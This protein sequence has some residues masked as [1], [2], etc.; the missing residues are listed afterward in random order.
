MKMMRQGSRAM[1][2]LPELIECEEK[3]EEEYDLFS[4][5]HKKIYIIKDLN[6][7]GRKG[8]RHRSLDGGRNKINTNN[9]YNYDVS[10]T[11]EEDWISDDSLNREKGKSQSKFSR[12]FNKIY[13]DH[14]ERPI[15]MKQIKDRNKQ[16]NKTLVDTPIN[17][18]SNDSSDESKVENASDNSSS[19]FSFKKK[20]IQA[21][22]DK[23]DQPSTK[24]V[25][26]SHKYYE[27]IVDP[28]EEDEDEND[29]GET[30]SLIRSETYE[31]FKT[32]NTRWKVFGKM[33]GNKER[34]PMR[35][36]SF[37][38]ETTSFENEPILEEND[39]E[40]D[41]PDPYYH[42]F[43]VGKQIDDSKSVNKDAAKLL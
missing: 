23:A 2:I 39:E 43:K 1:D 36:K 20:T 4:S 38:F 41:Q 7:F 34:V 29:N 3:L 10:E 21:F 35:K 22:Y 5:R 11:E 26:T 37:M 24:T 27:Q 25:A 42:Y 33:F 28:I 6:E 32:R 12:I 16:L 31:K 30:S 15:R 14:F 19:N 40:G 18:D 8:K 17:E 9:Y 13:A